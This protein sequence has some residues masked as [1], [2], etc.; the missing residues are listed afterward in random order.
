MRF[1]KVQSILSPVIIE[2]I[3]F[4]RV[5]YRSNGIEDDRAVPGQHLEFLLGYDIPEVEQCQLH[6]PY[7]DVQIA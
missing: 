3:R 5:V 1:Q 2:Q 4:Q 6:L 7:V